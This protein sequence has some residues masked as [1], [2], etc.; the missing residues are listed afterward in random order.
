MQL[1]KAKGLLVPFVGVPFGKLFKPNE[2]MDLKTD[3]GIVGKLLERAIG[4]SHS[5]ATLDFEDGEL[6]T[7]KCCPDGRPRETMFITQVSSVIDDILGMQPFLQTPLFKKCQNLLY[8]PVCKDGVTADWM[9]LPPIHVDLRTP[10][11]AGI[12]KQLEKDYRSIAEQLASHIENSA[13]GFIHTSNGE[14]IQVRS[15]DAMPYS[16]IYS[17]KYGRYVSNKNHAFY[18]RKE[19]M[20]GLQSQSSDYPFSPK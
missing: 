20:I 8:L 17:G 3:K 18:F 2:L 11:R 16:P 19:F 14:L 13:D 5:S 6:K 7:N 10:A 15:K 9:F 12:R 4:L 1:E